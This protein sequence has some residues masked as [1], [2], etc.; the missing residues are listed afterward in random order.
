[1]IREIIFKDNIIQYNLQYKNVKNI[2]MRIKPDGSINVSA[3][4]RVS[5]KVIDDF[6]NSKADF[7]LRA[8][9]KY[10]NMP[11]TEQKQYYTEDEVKELIILL[12]NFIINFG[13]WIFKLLKSSGSF[14]PI[15]F[16]CKLSLSVPRVF[17]FIPCHNCTILLI[18]FQALTITALG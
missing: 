17:V 1:M 2:N 6:I 8:L 14:S 12:C 3:N 11:V 5:Q 7:I 9:E 10:E 18:V 16:F 13:I 15:L 4:R